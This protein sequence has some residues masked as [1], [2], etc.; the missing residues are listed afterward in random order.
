MDTMRST[1]YLEN[2]ARGQ[3]NLLKQL[4]VQ[5]A[6]RCCCLQV[7]VVMSPVFRHFVL[8][9][10]QFCTILRTTL[11]SLAR[12][13]VLPCALS[14]RVDDK[15]HHVAVSASAC[16]NCIQGTKVITEDH[17]GGKASHRGIEFTRG[18]ILDTGGVL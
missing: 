13:F 8:P 15:W 6:M 1:I 12:N 14:C 7:V 9:C 5:E 10:A 17:R 4:I 2:Q 16:V 11:Y 18:V 3:K